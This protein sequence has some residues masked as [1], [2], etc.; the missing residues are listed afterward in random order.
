MSDV[1]HL[2]DAAVAGDR[3]AAAK[4]LPLVYDQL[5]EQAAARMS[6]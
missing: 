6:Q 2:L 1:T 5:R 3:V 4:L